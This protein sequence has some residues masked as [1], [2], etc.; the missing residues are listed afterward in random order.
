MGLTEVAR[1]RL[2]GKGFAKLFTDHQSEWTN[3]AE[4]A[5]KLIADQLA[6]GEPTVD[7]IKKTLSPLVE[8]HPKLREHLDGKKLTQKYWISDFTDYLLQKVYE[9]KLT[10][11]KHKGK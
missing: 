10:Q 2:E 3:M 11:P 6:H 9:P 7:D 5:K 4:K 8:L 1:I